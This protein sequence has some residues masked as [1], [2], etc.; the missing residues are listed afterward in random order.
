MY[1]FAVSHPCGIYWTNARIMAE[2]F[3][4]TFREGTGVTLPITWE[5]VSTGTEL[6][7]DETYGWSDPAEREDPE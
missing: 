3:V 7:D 1:G 2:R 5:R 6:D 4:E